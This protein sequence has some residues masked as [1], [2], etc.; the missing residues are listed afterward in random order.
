[1]V[2]SKEAQN[3]SSLSASPP[4]QMHHLINLGAFV[5]Y[6][7]KV[8]CI[9]CLRVTGSMLVA[10]ARHTRRKWPFAGILP[11]E[12]C[13][14]LLTKLT[15]KTR[16]TGTGFHPW[17]TGDGW[18]GGDESGGQGHP[19]KLGC[20]WEGSERKYSQGVLSESRCLQRSVY[21]VII[22]ASEAC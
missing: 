11:R 8:W 15:G 20:V 10:V 12:S 21:E 7:V 17:G 14:A 9:T 5:K 19:R 2:V 1:M 6:A 18:T 16:R 3:T 13:G 22:V 4:P